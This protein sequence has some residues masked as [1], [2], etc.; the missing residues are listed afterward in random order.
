MKKIIC[1]LLIFSM[2]FVFVSCG[3]DKTESKEGAATQSTVPASTESS[4]P[5]SDNIYDFNLKLNDIVYTFPSTIE[6]FEKNDWAIPDDKKTVNVDPGSFVEVATKN[7]TGYITLHIFNDS[8]VS[9]NLMACKVGG[10][11][12]SFNRSNTY[13]VELSKGIILNENLKIDDIVAAWGNYTYVEKT[14][15]RFEKIRTDN[16][17]CAYSF[18][19]TLDGT[20]Y[21]IVIKNDNATTPA[22]FT[23]LKGVKADIAAP[24]DKLTD[25]LN[26]GI[27]SLD[28][29]VLAFPLKLSELTSIKDWKMV[30]G[31]TKLAPNEQSSIILA[32]DLKTVSDDNYLALTVYN[33]TDK[34]I[35]VEDATVILLDYNKNKNVSALEFAQGIKIGMSEDA[36]LKA[37]AGYEFYATNSSDSTHYIY[38]G[39]EGKFSYTFSFSSDKLVGMDISYNYIIVDLDALL[40]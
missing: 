1:L 5:L 34:E 2:I 29:K 6:N 7:D 26:D 28:G 32:K 15:Y 33:P 3:E 37:T 39:D 4:L 11:T 22:A 27:I 10:I 16:N 17:T 40:G 9:Q 31:Y 18:D 24:A 23:T 19:T 35:A 14:L 30:M 13:N 21:S 36:F 20:V 25:D 38:S 8:D 12:L